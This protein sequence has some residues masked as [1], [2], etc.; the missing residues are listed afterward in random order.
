MLDIQKEPVHLA[1]NNYD[2]QR[3]N[4]KYDRLQKLICNSEPPMDVY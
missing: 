3:F 4:R 2:L 1:D